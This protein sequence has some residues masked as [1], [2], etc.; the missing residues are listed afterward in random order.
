MA[1]EHIA[2]AVV[3]DVGAIG[4]TFYMSNDTDIC[5]CAILCRGAEVLLGRRSPRK[6]YYPNVWDLPGG[7][8]RV[9]E[10][11]VA[12]LVREVSE[13]LGVVPTAFEWVVALDELDV[14]RNGEGVY[15]VFVVTAWTGGEPRLNN[16]EHTELRWCSASDAVGLELADPRYAELFGRVLAGLGRPT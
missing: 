9:G 4:Y 13:E 3:I 7:H 5:A 2:A 14:Q 15:N 6:R 1:A 8:V 10:S 11:L 16:R 12:G